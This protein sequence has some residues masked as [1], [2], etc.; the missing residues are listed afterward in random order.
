MFSNTLIECYT[1]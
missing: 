1:K